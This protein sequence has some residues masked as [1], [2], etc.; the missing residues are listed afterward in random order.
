MVSSGNVIYKSRAFGAG[1]PAT[2]IPADLPR[3]ASKPLLISRHLRDRLHIS[4]IILNR[5]GVVQLFYV[6]GL[7][8]DCRSIDV[9]AYDAGI[10]YIDAC[11]DPM[12]QGEVR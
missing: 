2:Q 6:L 4:G 12:E 8:F 9:S 3:K 10:E 5:E 7:R 1:G 11:L